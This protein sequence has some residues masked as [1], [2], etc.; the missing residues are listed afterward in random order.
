ME[1]LWLGLAVLLRM[2]IKQ[3]ETK[4]LERLSTWTLKPPMV[5]PCGGEGMSQTPKA[6]MTVVEWSG[7]EWMTVQ[8]WDR[9][10]ISREQEPKW[11]KGWCK[12]GCTVQKQYWGATRMPA[13]ALMVLRCEIMSSLHW[14]EIQRK[15]FSEESWFL[16]KARQWRKHCVNRLWRWRDFFNI[17]Q[18]FHKVRKDGF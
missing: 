3:L 1:E 15:L 18:G 16:P 13:L 2:K 5:M 17:E 14:R 8:N 11:I 10:Y 6:F 12:R 7:T 4:V 9:R